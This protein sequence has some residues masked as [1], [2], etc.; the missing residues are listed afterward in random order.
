MA[1]EISVAQS[2]SI[3]EAGYDEYWLQDQIWS[4]PTALG[5][6][7]LDALS[8]ERRQNSGGRLDILLKDPQDDSMYEVEVMLGETDETH[9]IRTIEYWDNEKRRWPQRQHY[10]VLVAEQIT[11]RFF[12]VIHILSHSIPIIAIQVALIEVS[13]KR[14]LY[15]T[16][17]LDTFE[18]VDDGSTVTEVEVNRDFWN[19][20]AKWTAD[21]ADK[22]LSVVKTELID[23]Q[24]SYVKNYIAITVGRNNYFWLHKRSSNKS[25]LGFRIAAHLADDAQQVLDDAKISFT[26][27]P[28]SIL[29]TVDSATVESNAEAFSKLASLVRRTWEKDA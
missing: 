20:K 5:L 24:P 1:E 3:R 18:E 10:A 6:G 4:N 19:K 11:R 29:V 21:T 15:F 28:K 2:V 12:N 7:D 25:L 8:K 16:K 26:R 9:I 13:G 17:V 14:S 23:P 27:K 22:L